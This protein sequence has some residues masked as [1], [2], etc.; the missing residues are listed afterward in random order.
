MLVIAFSFANLQSQSSVLGSNDLLAIRNYEL[1]KIIYSDFVLGCGDK[2]GS[3]M[4]PMG[5]QVHSWL[6]MREV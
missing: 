6:D 3:N 2:I 1:I 4:T 5:S